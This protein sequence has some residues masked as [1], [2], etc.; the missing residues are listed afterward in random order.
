MIILVL[1]RF[2][3]SLS[4]KNE[5]VIY[6]LVN[7][8]NIYSCIENEYI[9]NIN[10]LINVEVKMNSVFLTGKIVSDIEYRFVINKSKTYS[11]CKFKVELENGIVFVY[12]INGIS[13]FCYRYFK[14]NTYICIY[15]KIDSNMEIEIIEII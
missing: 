13:D 4:G 15:G 8:R 10:I 2:I 3:P 12:S 14:K 1:K 11:K 7:K 5:S 6:M 9:T